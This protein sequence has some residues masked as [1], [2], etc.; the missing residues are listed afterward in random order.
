MVGDFGM[1]P[2][3]FG[4]K[5]FGWFQTGNVDSQRIQL[6]QIPGGSAADVQKGCTLRDNLGSSGSGGT[7][8]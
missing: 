3:A 5:R 4:E 6:S 1:H 7:D 8:S 2:P